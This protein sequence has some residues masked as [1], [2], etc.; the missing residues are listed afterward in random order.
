[1]YFD[2]KVFLHNTPA[3]ILFQDMLDEIVGLPPDREHQNRISEDHLF[4]FF[5]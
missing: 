2:M 3:Q 1:M 4:M 5:G